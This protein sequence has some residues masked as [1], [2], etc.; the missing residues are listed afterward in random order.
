[1][2]VGVGGSIPSPGWGWGEDEGGGC[3]MNG[4][5]LGRPAFYLFILLF[6]FVFLFLLEALKTDEESYGF[7]F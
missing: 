5:V 2:H 4:C 6:F 1:M 3:L 7:L